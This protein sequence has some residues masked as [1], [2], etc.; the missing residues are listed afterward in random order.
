MTRTRQ[1]VMRGAAWLAT[2]AAEHAVTYDAH[3][4]C[5]PRMYEMRPEATDKLLPVAAYTLL[6]AGEEARTDSKSCIST[7]MKTPVSTDRS[8]PPACNAS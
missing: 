5:R 4:P 7:P 3:G 6:P 8:S 1:A 2:R